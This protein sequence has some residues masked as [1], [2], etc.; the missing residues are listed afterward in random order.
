MR[1]SE[2]DLEDWDASSLTRAVELNVDMWG[3]AKDLFW[4]SLASLVLR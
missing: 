4:A 1:G 3:S 2:R